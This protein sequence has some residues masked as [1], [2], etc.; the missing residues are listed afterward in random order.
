MAYFHNACTVRK[1]KVIPYLLICNNI[2]DIVI[3][4]KIKLQCVHI[5]VKKE[6]EQ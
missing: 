1:K 4:N 3:E 2:Q 6:V 5:C